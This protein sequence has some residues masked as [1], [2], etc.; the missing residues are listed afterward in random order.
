MH[1]GRGASPRLRALSLRGLRASGAGRARR[2]VFEH[3]DG[4]RVRAD[5]GG[6]VRRVVGIA[7]TGTLGGETGAKVADGHGRRPR[8]AVHER[9]RRHEAVHGELALEDDLARAAE[10][11]GALPL[12]GRSGI[13]CG[14]LRLDDAD[15]GGVTVA[16]GGAD[17]DA[18][19]EGAAQRV[20]L[21]PRQLREA[22]G[23]ERLCAARPEQLD[24]VACYA[25]TSVALVRFAALLVKVAE[26]AL[27]AEV[28]RVPLGER[29][30]RRV[31]PQLAQASLL[32]KALC[33]PQNARL[34]ALRVRHGLV[35][36]VRVVPGPARRRF[37][38]DAGPNSRRPSVSG[39]RRLR[40]KMEGRVGG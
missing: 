33:G 36:A 22:L 30:Q 19:G 29:A 24:R 20:G 14:K 40:G 17:A 25:P 18:S 32:A 8:L 11:R 28:P 26:E 34:H 16:H 38:C 13:R 31:L 27:L 6:H 12:R 23:G 9:A 15:D 5:L 21:A 35:L 2:L 7:A 3:R 10:E 4:D 1:E 37:R 39:R